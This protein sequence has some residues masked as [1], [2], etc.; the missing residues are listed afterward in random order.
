M[1]RSRHWIVDTTGTPTF[2]DTR[3]VCIKNSGLD[4]TDALT[5][6]ADKVVKQLSE[7]SG[8]IV[9]KNSPS[10]GL[11]GVIVYD[12]NGVPKHDGT[13]LYIKKIMEAKPILPMAEEDQLANFM[14]RD[15]FFESVFVY[16][17]WQQLQI[18]GITLSKLA[19][20]HADHQYLITSR[21]SPVDQTLNRLV[22]SI[23]GTNLYR[24]ADNYIHQ[25][26]FVLK[27]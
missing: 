5:A 19:A 21:S 25:L 4:V 8:Y 11:A 6:Y 16:H 22:A 15:N 1:S 12:D 24:L 13:G 23:N 10:C 20:F 27:Q 2:N 14:W 3:T 18:S 7:I 26:M 9:K 17:Q